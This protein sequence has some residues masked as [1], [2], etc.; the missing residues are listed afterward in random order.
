D[1]KD[2]K[3]SAQEIIEKLEEE[4]KRI[5]GAAIEFFQPPAVPGYGAAGGFE[6]RLLD[7]AG[8]GDYKKMEEVSRDFVKELNKRKELA[9]VFT[10]YSA[11]FPQYMLKIDN[12]LAQ[13]K[14]VT[15]DNAMSTLSTL[16]GSNYETSFIKFDRQYKVIVQALP[17]YRALPDDILKLYVKND[18]DEI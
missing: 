16:I 8:S 14:G 7:K 18:R 15:I 10:F 6:L 9:S 11:S 3:A 1:W 17:Q 5:P 4:A 12:D 13:Q 2:R